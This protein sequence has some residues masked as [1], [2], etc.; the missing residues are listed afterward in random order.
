MTFTEQSQYFVERVDLTADR[1]GN[2]VF[3]LKE[4]VVE[5]NIYETLAKPY[6]TGQL[7]VVDNT[8]WRDAIQIKG[9]E[10][11]TLGIK[12]HKD[13]PLVERRFLVTEILSDVSVN[14]RTDVRVLNLIEEHGY[15]NT[16]K[17]IS[18][19]YTAKPHDIIQAIAYDHLGLFVN[20][21]DR[22]SLG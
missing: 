15:L 17:K 12:A 20:I 8:G 1:L 13:A 9:T 19:A 14:D 5:T 18:Q 7:A 11:I 4:S 6:L 21:T 10:R 2:R 3:D 22:P 16:L